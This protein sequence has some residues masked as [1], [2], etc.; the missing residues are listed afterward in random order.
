[1]DEKFLFTQF[2]AFL[3]AVLYFLSY[4]LRDN[5]KL[6]AMQFFRTLFIRFISFFW[7]Q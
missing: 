7:E 2:L 1:M 6:Y 3:G 5:R 4:Q